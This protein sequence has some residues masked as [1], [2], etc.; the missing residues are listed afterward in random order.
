M[1]F[2][3]NDGGRAAA[4]F[5]GESG[6]CVCRAIAIASGLPY[7][8]VYKALNAGSRA[9]R[10]PKP[11]KGA[12]MRSSARNGVFTGKAWFKRYMTSIGA[13][14]VP[15]MTIGSGCTVHVRADELLTRRYAMRL[16]VLD[17]LTIRRCGA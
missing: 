10:L 4:G 12:R 7:T 16:W 11:G 2:Q 9:E 6:D 14:W 15:C 5:A 3:H 17:F 1:S 8:D 13:R